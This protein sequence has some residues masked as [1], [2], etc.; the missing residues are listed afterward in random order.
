MGNSADTDQAESSAEAIPII[1]R[2]LAHVPGKEHRADFV[3]VADLRL[4][5]FAKTKNAEEC[6]KTAE[7][8]EKIG[9]TDASSYYNAAC[10]RAVT[11][12]VILETDKSPAGK[13]KAD[14]EADRAMH[15]LEQ[16][17]AAGF[18]D[19]EDAQRRHGF[20]SATEAAGF[21]ESAGEDRSQEG[22]EVG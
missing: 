12:A 9:S 21:H 14:E 20:G 1:D 6:H 4:R 8:W 15:W 3:L 10:I 13:K 22:V 18:K 11:A 19:S 5:H 7:M 2:C 16:A 17:I